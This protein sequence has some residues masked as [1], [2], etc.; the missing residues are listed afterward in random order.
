MDEIDFNISMLLMANSRIPYRELAEIF[1]MSV[2]SIHKRV[3]S[4]VDKGIIQ[5]FNMRLSSLNFPN[6]ANVVMFGISK[7]MD[8]KTLIEKI[9]S[10]ECI[11]NVTQASSNLFYIHAYI[12]NLSQLDSVVSFIRQKGEINELTIG[13]DKGVT[14]D[15]VKDLGD[16]S[17]SKLD[18]LIVN[19]L[20]DN[21]RKT[22]SDV[23]DEIGISP[24]TIRRHLN[25]L[26]EKN[27]VDFRIDW[28]PDK[29]A[30]ILSIIILK[31]KPSVDFDDVK[32]LEDL[33]EKC[34]QK[35]LFSWTFSN[36]PNLIL[37]CIWT[38]S[39]K[40]LQGI[41]AFLMS[42]Q[43]E[44]VEVTVL[45]EGKMFPTWQD[46]FLEDKMKEIKQNRT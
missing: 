8:P 35:V 23:A 16:I 30:E 36:L 21:S 43:F 29:T 44:S 22:I 18:Y 24:K 38:S 17:L 39:M 11:Y 19:S 46:T 41:E 34:S 31:A 13:L 1:N 3:K 9:G 20:K 10:H 40:E 32:L 26:I 37:V 4:M 12:R 6:M 25:R 14:S 27:L 5:N 15:I 45:I 33:R 7:I 42:K 2:N 28:Y